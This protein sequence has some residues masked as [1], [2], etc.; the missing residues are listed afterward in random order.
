MSVIVTPS[1]ILDITSQESIKLTKEEINTLSFTNVITTY[2]FATLKKIFIIPDNLVVNQANKAFFAEKKLIEG[3]YTITLTAK[4][5][6]K[7]NDGTN[8]LESN[9]FAGF[10]ILDITSKTSITNITLEDVELID[11]NALTEEKF[12]IVKKAFHLVGITNFEQAHSLFVVSKILVEET[13]EYQIVLTAR[14]GYLFDNRETTLSSPPFTALF[15]LNVVNQMPEEIE[16]TLQETQLFNGEMINHDQ[17]I[18]LKKI[19]TMNGVQNFEDA[20]KFFVVTNRVVSGKYILV[21]TPQHGYTINGRREHISNEFIAIR[22]LDVVAKDVNSLIMEEDIAK[23]MNEGTISSHSFL[24]LQKIFTMSNIESAND[25]NNKF[26][27]TGTNVG[28]NYTLTLI[29]KDGFQFSDRTTSLTSKTIFTSQNILITAIPG[30]SIVIYSREW[31][32]IQTG[33]LNGDNFPIVQK[34][35]NISGDLLTYQEYFTI[36]KNIDNNADGGNNSI[37]LIAK[38]G[39]VI[40]ESADLTSYPF[41][42]TKDAQITPKPKDQQGEFKYDAFHNMNS[43]VMDNDQAKV[44]SSLFNLPNEIRFP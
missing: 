4:P 17:F 3:L 43:S 31:D 29:A 38:R 1:I 42:I 39:F 8:K 11:G 14:E 15:D 7:F 22:I 10:D 35:F 24:I 20:N 9:T 36:E 21:L 23:L 19:F 5:G 6:F 2:E 33:E 40:N 28:Q 41:K 34:V 30:V 16:I 27:V 32:L 37:K 12:I 13:N 44:I 26:L 18:I 25:V